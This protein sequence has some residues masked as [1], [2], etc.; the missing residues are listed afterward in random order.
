MILYT[1]IFFSLY[2]NGLLKQEWCYK[3]THA[4]KH[5]FLNT[6]PY[7]HE[8]ILKMSLINKNFIYKEKSEIATKFKEDNLRSIISLT[9]DSWYYHRTAAV[10]KMHNI[11]TSFKTLASKRAAT[12]H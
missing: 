8:F 1:L 2:T 9:L 7:K 3:K 5:E 10:E 11:R 12:F 6:C 4:S